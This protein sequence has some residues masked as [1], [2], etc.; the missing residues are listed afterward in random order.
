MEKIKKILEEG[1]RNAKIYLPLV[2]LMKEIGEPLTIKDIAEKTGQNYELTKH[3][4]HQLSETGVI[5]RTKPGFY[6]LAE[7]FERFKV[8]SVES[9]CVTIWS[10][11]RREPK[12]NNIR[13]QGYNQ[14]LARIGKNDFCII[15]EKD[16]GVMELRRNNK[17]FGRKI[18]GLYSGAFEIVISS[19]DIKEETLQKLTYK[20][21]RKKMIYY[22]REWGLTVKNAIG[23]ENVRD[24]ELAGELIKY[25]LIEKPQ[26][27]GDI[28]AD[29]IFKRNNETVY[30]E[31]TEADMKNKKSSIKNNQIQARM[32]YGL[33]CNQMYKC[34]MVIVINENW[35]NSKWLQKEIAFLK[36][37]NVHFLFTNFKENWEKEV[38]KKV[39]DFTY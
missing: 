30:V 12:T 20:A 10:S 37:N 39:L 23:S 27:T 8:K 31:L 38:C 9:E 4:L 32:Y 22:P 13:I 21:L 33:K 2:N 1:G 19:K 35:K 5:A 7:E 29:I 15:S 11:M 34:P 36:S 6:F 3:R 17:F 16:D 28:K 25:G 14:P 24:G 26:K 18:Y